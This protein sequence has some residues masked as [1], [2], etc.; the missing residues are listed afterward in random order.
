MHSLIGNNSPELAASNR[1]WVWIIAIDDRIG[2]KYLVCKTLDVVKERCV[3]LNAQLLDI[4]RAAKVCRSVYNEFA[5]SYGLTTHDFCMDRR[6][7]AIKLNLG[8]IKL[9]IQIRYELAGAS[10]MSPKVHGKDKPQA[11][12]PRTH[13]DNVA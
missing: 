4:S 9:L 8:N 5:T 3:A 7:R 11:G 1:L 13:V 10:L 6:K 2:R 12:K